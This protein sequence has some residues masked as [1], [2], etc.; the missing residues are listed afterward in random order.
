MLLNLQEWVEIALFPGFWNHWDD[1]IVAPPP[2]WDYL[3]IV[4]TCWYR[5]CHHWW[6]QT[7]ALATA[8]VCNLT[9]LK[10]SGEGYRSLCCSSAQHPSFH[11]FSFSARPG[12]SASASTVKKVVIT[13]TVFSSILWQLQQVQTRNMLLHCVSVM[14]PGFFLKQKLK[15]RSLLPPP[16]PKGIY[17]SSSSSHWLRRHYYVQRG[18]AHKFCNGKSHP[19]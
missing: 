6:L 19:L 9:I 11:A 13:I 4:G 16:P 15:Q 7:F 14:T 8:V 17:F 2:T 12:G 5:Q 3:D 10:K 1:S 18:R